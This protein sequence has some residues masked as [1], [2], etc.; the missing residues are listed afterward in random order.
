MRIYSELGHG[1]TVRLYLPRATHEQAR[2]DPSRE[3]EKKQKGQSARVLIVEDN[4]NLAKS[5]NRVLSE[6][7]YDVA[8]AANAGE[9]LELLRT[10]SSLDLLFTDIILAHGKNG[11]ELA[12]E[13][14]KLKPDIKVLFS[15]GF[16]EA[17]LR[18]S[19]R[20]VVSG[21]FIAKPYRKGELVSR[22]GS[23]IGESTP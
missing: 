5:A 16:S 3:V 8:V 23:L 14:A 12:Q 17:A 9:A 20:A 10:N 1:T 22:I 6:A 7:G 18:A 21:H 19:G 11:I 15:S 4:A 2:L 13:A